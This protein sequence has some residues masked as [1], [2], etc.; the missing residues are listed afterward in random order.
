MAEALPT[1]PP[2]TIAAFRAAGEA[3]VD[4][5]ARRVLERQTAQAPRGA[6]AE[7]ILRE[8]MKHTTMALE[9]AMRFQAPDLLTQ[10][11]EWAQARLPHDG[12]AAIALLE[13]LRLYADVVAEILPPTD[14]EQV[15]AYV[16]YLVRL[17]EA[18]V[19]RQASRRRSPPTTDTT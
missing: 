8:G 4:V 10:Q 5:A 3:I 18:H 9:A 15:G 17:Q 13:N 12:I 6:K 14:G 11:M 2:A 7:R 16:A 1:V 19:S